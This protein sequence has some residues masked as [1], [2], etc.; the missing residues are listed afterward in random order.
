MEKLTVVPDVVGSGFSL[1]AP[2]I[3]H[4]KDGLHGTVAGFLHRAVLDVRMLLVVL[5]WQRLSA[6]TTAL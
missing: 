5:N 2:G 6:G 3:E 1:F 4:V